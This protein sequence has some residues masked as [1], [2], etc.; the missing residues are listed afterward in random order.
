MINSKFKI[1]DSVR[2]KHSGKIYSTYPEMYVKLGFK[3][4]E[5][6]DYY[7][8]AKIGTV[9]GI[10]EHLTFREDILVAVR[11]EDGNEYLIHQDGLVHEFD[12]S[13]HEGRLA[14]AR[15]HY[16]IGTKYIPIDS[17]GSLYDTSRISTYAP[18]KGNYDNNIHCGDGF[19]YL[20]LGKGKWAE[21][22][23]QEEIN[24]EEFIVLNFNRGVTFKGF[25]GKIYIIPTDGSVGVSHYS[26]VIRHTAI[27]VNENGVMCGNTEMVA[28]WKEGIG[29]VEIIKEEEIMETQKLSRQGLKEIYEIACWT[30]K[31]QLEKW[32]IRNPFENYVDLTQEE[33]DEM[34][35]ACT[36]EQLPI[37]SKYLKQDDGSVDVMQFRCDIYDKEGRS[38]I[39]KRFNGEYARKSLLLDHYYNWEIK[40]DD[41]GYLCLIPTKKK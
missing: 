13:T 6:N 40:K 27:L 16:P 38:V 35:K 17:L 20:N 22:I 12:M 15:K 5:V 18:K 19:I 9:F 24:K 21:I 14:Y 8:C 10:S 23:K 1:G 4:K 37:V 41:E 32:G 39:Q 28:I 2:I 34:F 29:F 3:D 26:D 30:W 7:T 31:V 33:V 36:K 11:D 25:D